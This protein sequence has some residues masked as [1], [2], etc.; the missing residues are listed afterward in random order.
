MTQFTMMIKYDPAVCALYISWNILQN[1][2][3]S[4][5]PKT[6]TPKSF[7]MYVCSLNEFDE[8]HS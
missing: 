4:R 7:K 1:K 6:T 5:K 8:T 3:T 2:N